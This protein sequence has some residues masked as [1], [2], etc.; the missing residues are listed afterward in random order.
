MELGPAGGCACSGEEE[1]QVGG[2][3]PGAR[4]QVPGTTK[5]MGTEAMDCGFGAFLC[6]SS[7]GDELGRRGG[8]RGAGG[9]A[10]GLASV[11]G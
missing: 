8:H 11:P 2:W 5:Q 7:D 3:V 4:Y 9:A 10:E 6:L 1:G